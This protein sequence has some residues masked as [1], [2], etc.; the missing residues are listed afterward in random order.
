LCMFKMVIGLNR[1]RGRTWHAFWMVCHLIV[2]SMH[3]AEV[4]WV[5]YWVTVGAG[6]ESAV[7]M[8]FWNAWRLF[9]SLSSLQVLYSSRCLVTSDPRSL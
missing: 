1:G 3:I 2:L 5:V 8:A 6:D 7:R 9:D 4:R